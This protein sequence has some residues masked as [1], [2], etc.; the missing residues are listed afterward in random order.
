[1]RARENVYPLPCTGAQVP[2][3]PLF[4]ALLR[5]TEI[6]EPPGQIPERRFLAQRSARPTPEGGIYS[7]RSS[8]VAVTPPR[9]HQAPHFHP[10]PLVIC[11]SVLL[12]RPSPPHPPPKGSMASFKLFYFHF[13]ISVMVCAGC[14]VFQQVSPNFL[15]GTLKE[16]LL[17]L[18]LLFSERLLNC[19]WNGR[20]SSDVWRPC[21]LAV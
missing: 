21:A 9:R 8:V 10:L 5:R 14:L 6:P 18:L 20:F 19:S 17:L 3:A 11:P 2:R 16:D 1:M 4:Q 12:T 7:I 15:E 13:K